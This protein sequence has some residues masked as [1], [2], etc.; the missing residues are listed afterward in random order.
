[1]H[2]WLQWSTAMK[3]VAGP[4]PVSE[5]VASVHHIASGRSVVMVPS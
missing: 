3:M 4:S 1:M 5:L 2:S